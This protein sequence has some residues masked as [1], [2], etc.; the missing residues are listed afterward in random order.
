MRIITHSTV[1]ENET[2]LTSVKRLI[3]LFVLFLL[4]ATSSVT[5][6]QNRSIS[7]QTNSNIDPSTSHIFDQGCF[8]FGP[9]NLEVRTIQSYYQNKKIATPPLGSRTVTAVDLNGA[10]AGVDATI[11]SVPTPGSVGPTT[12]F[13]AFVTTTSGSMTSAVFSFTGAVDGVNELIG[14]VDSGSG[15]IAGV[16]DLGSAFQPAT[17]ITA[18]TVTLRVTNPAVGVLNV[19]RLGGGPIP[20]SDFNIF[21]SNFLYGNQLNP[22]ATEGT[23]IMNVAVT[24]PDNTVSAN[25]FINVGFAPVAVDD[26][27]SILANAVTPVTGNLL[28]NDSDPTPGDS[29]SISEVNG[30]S[31]SVG[32]P[33]A[34]TYGT[35]TV[36]AN[37]SYSYSVDVSNIAVAGLSAGESIDD[38]ISY[39]V[40]DVLGFT[41][42]GFITITING[43]DE[44]PVATDNTN[45]VTVGTSPTANG[46]VIFD[47]D[48]FGVDTADRPLAIFVWENEFSAPGGV[49]GG[50]SGPV[51]GQ[52]RTEA[53][54]GVTVSFT[55]SDPDNIGIPDQDQVVYQTFTNGGHF[56]YFGFAVDA[57]VNPSASSVLTMDFDEPVVNLSF[58]L[59]DID[60]SQGDSWQDLMTV[61]GSNGG[62]PVSFIPQVSGSVV[63]VGVD[64]FY[65][66]GSVVPE[67]AHGNVVINFPN[68]VTQVVVAYNY[69]PD[70]TAADNGGQIAAISDMIWQATGAPRVSAVDG[71]AANVGVSYATTYGFITLNS[72]GTYTYTVDAANPAVATLPVGSTLM[73]VIPYTLIDSIGPGGN[74]DT[75]NLTI[76]IN[77]SFVACAITAIA[78]VSNND[79]DPGTDTFT[80]DVTVTF[81]GAPATGTLDLTGDGTA[82]VAVGSLD[83]ATSHTFTGVTMVADGAAIDLTATFS[84]DVACTFNEPNAGTADPSCAASCGITAIAAV[85]NNDCDPGT[86]TFTA[87]VTVTFSTPPATGTL[88]LTG[89]GTASVAVGSLDTPTSHTFAGVTMAA[90]GGAIDLTAT[91][92]D[93]VACTLNEPNAGTADAS[94]APT[95]AVTAIAAVSNNDCDPGTD[96]FTADVTVN[97]IA[98]P[99]TGTLD[100]TGDGT[101]SVAVGSLDTPTSHTFAGVTMAAD[102]SAID[103]TAT[104][105]DDITCTFNEPNAGTA[106]SSCVPL[107]DGDGVPAAVEDA[108]PNG[109]DGNNDGI[110]DST[111]GNV[112]SLPD[113]SGTGT[114]VT[115]EISSS[116]CAQITNI[117]TITE[118]AVGELD[119]DFDYPV[120]LVDFTAICVNPGDSAM[121]NYWWHGIAAID[122]FRKYGSSAPGAGDAT[123]DHYLAGQYME[124][125]AGNMVPRTQYQITDDLPGDESATPTEIIDPAGPALASFPT[126]DTD[127]DTV[128]NAI[129]LDDDNDG[130]L[131]TDEMDCAPAFI[132]LGQT[133]SSTAVSGTVANTFAYGGV[134][135]TLGYELIGSN[136]GT[137]PAWVS[138]VSN[139]NNGGIAPD[140]EYANFQP[141]NTDFL[142]GDVSVYTLDFINGPVFNLEFKWGGLDNSDRLDVLASVGGTNVPVTI[143]DINLGGNLNILGPQSVFS[144][145]GGANAP[146]NSIQIRIDGPVDQVIVTTGKQ[147]G[148][149]GT[150]TTQLYEMIYCVPIDTDGDGLYDHLD[151]DADN[152][153]IYDV[154]ETGGTDVNGDGMA[155]DTDGD[156]TNNNGVPNT[157]NGGAGNPPINSD[158][159][160]IP[161]FQD[162]DSD[163]DGCSDANE[164]FNDA[165]ADGGD[166]EQ[167]GTS[168][169]L[170]IADGEVN[171]DG[172]VVA[173]DYSTGT[174]SAV[175]TP[176]VD[177]DGDGLVGACDPD[178][179]G[180][181]NP[182]TT[183]PNPLVPTA[184]DDSGTATAGVPEVIN[185]IGNDDFLENNNAGSTNPITISDTG[186]GTAGGVVTFDPDTGELTY[187]ALPGEGGTTVTVV[188]QVC[189][190]FA[191]LG[192]PSGPEDVCDTAVVT[193]T[194]AVGD[195]D[196]DGVPDDVDVCPGF[197]DNADADGDMVPDGCDED[198]DNDGILDSVECPPV[199]MLG[200]T[201]GGTGMFIDNVH[202]IEW[203]DTDWADG[204]QIG[205]QQVV[206]LANGDVVTLTVSA[207]IDNAPG[208]TD[209]W[210]PSGYGTNGNGGF[211]TAYPSPPLGRIGM[212]ANGQNGSIT[213]DIA[214][215]DAVGNTVVLD[216]VF[217]DP[218]NT[219]SV[220]EWAEANTNGSV[221]TAIESFTDPT[222]MNSGGVYSGVGTNTIRSLNNSTQGNSLFRS[223]GASQIEINMQ[224]TGGGRSA[225]LLGIFV[226]QR[227]G[228]TDTDGD[229]VIDCL[230]LDSDNDGIY[231]VVEAGGTDANNDGM[232]DGIDS[233]GNGIPDSAGTGLIPTDSGPTPGT[234]DYLDADSDEDGC[235]DAN[236]AYNDPTADGGDGGQY[237][238]DPAAVNPDG[239][240]IAAS[241]TTGAV[242]AVTTPDVDLDGDGLVGVCDPDNDG[243]GNPDTT[244]P[245][246]TTPNATD[247]A[248]A[249]DVGVPVTVS[250]LDN[251][252]YLDNNDPNNLGTTTV[253][254]TGT[255][256][257]MGTVTIDPATGEITYIPTA[258][259]AGTDVT[260]VY[261]VCNDE[262]GTPVCS[263]ATVT[264]TVS[265]LPDTDGDGIND[266]VDLDDDN[267]GILDTD[268]SPGLPPPSFDDDNDGVPNYLDPDQPG[269]VDTNGD[270][271]D[272][273]YDFDGDGIPNHFDLDADNDGIY[274]VAESGGI[275]ADNDGIADGLVD[276]NGVPSS[277]GGGNAPIE[278]TPGI[279]DHLNND[280]DGDGCTDANEAYDDPTAD[281][282]DAGQYGTDPA[283]VNPDG[284]VVA[285][286][287]GAGQSPS[288]SA[289]RTADID[290]DGDGL[291][292]AC[293]PDD[294]GDG[295]PDTTDPDPTTPNAADDADATDVGVPV[296]VSV[297]DND[298]YLD[299]NDPN[300]LGTTTVTDTGTGTAMGTVTIDPA[301]G[302]ITYIPTAAEAGTDVTIVYQV[303]NDE[304][305][306]PVC[307][308][309]TVTITVTGPDSDG[310]G[311]NDYID[312]DDDNDGILDTDESPG[313]P[314]PSFDDDNDGV[315]NYLDPDQP[316]YVDANGDGVDDR[317]DFDGDGIPN[318]LDLD[319][320]NDGIYDVAESGGTDA[321]NDGIADG[322]EDANGVPSSAGGGNTPIETTPGISDHLNNDSDGDGCTDANEAYND[323]TA[324]G[325]DAGQYGTDPAAVNP[326]GTVVAA[327]Y[328]AGQSPSPSAVTTADVDLDGDGLV[329][330]C[331]PDADGDGNPDTTD[332]DPTTPLA[333]DDSGATD[334]GVPV[335]IDI[336]GNDDYL[337]NSDPNNQGTTTITDTGTGTAGGTIVFDA[338]TGELTYTP[339][340][341]EAG[342]MVTVVY[343]VCN[344]ESG[345][346]ICV[347]ATVTIDVGDPDTDG[348]G[349]PDST[350]PDPNDPCVFTAGSTPDPSNPIWQAA[351]CDGDGTTNGDENTNGTDPNDPCEDD[352]TIGDEDT[353]NPVWQ[354]ADCDGDGVTNGQEDTD[355]TNPYDGCDYDPANQD[356]TTTSTTYQNADCDGDGVTNGDEID[357]DGNGVDDGNGTDPFDPC[358]YNPVLITLTQTAA[359]LTADCDGDGVTNGQEVIDG[360]DPLDPCDYNATSQVVANVT[361]AWNAL[362]CDGDGV[363]N[364]D[365]ITDG[366]DPQDPCDYVD[367]N[368]TVA[369]TATWNALDCD[370][371]GVTNGDEVADG[372]DPLDE[373]DLIYT[374]QTVPPS[375]A[376][377]AGD[378]DGDGVT[379][380]DEITDGTDPTD[381]CDFMLSS[382]TVPTT[383]A[384]EALDCDGDGVTNGDEIADGTDPSDPC[385]LDV[386]SQ[387][388]SPTAAW[389]A[390]DCDGDGVTNGDEVT[391]GTD[392]TD[393]C[394][395]VLASQTLPPT[396]AWND[397]DCDGDGVTNG[398]EV[399]DGTDPQDPC[400]L[401]YTSQTV[402]PTTAWN[403]TDCDGD[404]VTNGDEIT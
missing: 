4:T 51:G 3:F 318:H 96:T 125:V 20:T 404:G 185:I 330:V 95:C 184:V 231:D 309:A 283:A 279:S 335:V 19:A 88:D 158:G 247:D 311:I 50:L 257:A 187:T 36:L 26:A 92:S 241:Y 334:P 307:S 74:T 265:D 204:W 12:E 323:P 170:T 81:S 360:T 124:N 73:D 62:T 364:G 52:N 319:A 141:N 199:T 174:N 196:G 138:G 345:T 16:F 281:G 94:C 236:E 84:D 264:I 254:D 325:G 268:E 263:T 87:D 331:D 127:G 97:F 373:C 235:S 349:D 24:D 244:D 131:D 112:A 354:A 216:F 169:P 152:D 339:L 86:D 214:A 114:Y 189:N 132:A 222:T 165:N 64:T 361:A 177:L 46:D 38:I 304:S 259:E 71:S 367:G 401:D 389:D 160:G 327:A 362:D 229:G 341:S 102:G 98:P 186:L 272:D 297:L 110:L 328:G 148:N 302:E 108:G 146:N 37:G 79:C 209:G 233:D 66:T 99:A 40:Q 379:N 54:T 83:T 76:T 355:G 104:F 320:D 313:L 180:D 227:P 202:I 326:D 385:S 117:Q 15:A 113:A 150:V 246:P 57:N 363:I 207:L 115:L 80:A 6:A 316:G 1:P 305:G 39:G 167:Y 381:P 256:T 375:A 215:V 27:N 221:W 290:L 164:A 107:D 133:F 234:P 111:Q 58:T 293:D 370:G 31:A 179:D 240:V 139:Q 338:S 171:A 329:G 232:A 347:Q 288:P 147:N 195:Q 262:S 85:S 200:N 291:V 41:D 273:R 395:F 153:G 321:D 223:D 118:S 243:D 191:P 18:G 294:D 172:T 208:A 284:T 142:L 68:P 382:Q 55:S 217:T 203:T 340:P 245:D 82:S 116:T 67:D 33:F 303:C 70:A 140:G 75:A 396:T 343:E 163:D 278:T 123:Y 21:L 34:S 10:G 120:G 182:D 13:G 106:D 122:F 144:T 365:E 30:Y 130:I 126:D 14:I 93:D 193:I 357:P 220:V 230:D 403:D 17:N 212:S 267:D 78:A 155:D 253:T 374:S 105:S 225:L 238:T 100:L 59:S 388:V 42:F 312:L 332:P 218:E 63:T 181:G 219:G 211:G 276:A 308:T 159:D 391:D 157:A 134:D 45:A 28:A 285:A 213:F 77:G 23:R 269:Y 49:F 301:T 255:G 314:P 128:I 61:T 188:Y 315:P 383:P 295:N 43:V 299:N 7:S 310:D 352:G 173:A 342:M 399:A 137:T 101:A 2:L 298:D 387:T 344:D 260:I 178:D 282:G 56:G 53:T 65:G 161:D 287:Y 194:V 166:G 162:T 201:T 275:D 183:D 129:D 248:D 377:E 324:D 44:L 390:L 252:D 368:Q 371:D 103:L 190:D 121:I 119:A 198:D 266:Y 353:T 322:L 89:D 251:D 197:D 300:N 348:D 239:T 392:P 35:I 226:A 175:T 369:V 154:V 393:P 333:A 356:Y 29:I 109:G 228:N 205:D 289:V 400:S 9:E 337:D 372:T 376:W 145:A 306:T 358:D 47:D 402:P 242:A 206:N 258:A 270:G 237:G 90:D 151:L 25:S 394:D 60:W 249:T 135:I 176:D 292:G 274:D 250:V 397:A 136:P 378:C 210:T 351:D 398:D 168:D 8:R 386:A 72:D 271:V 5:L 261:Q 277:A 286:A 143:T 359:W 156:P 224:S 69:G 380:G 91:F 317:Y 384:W 149:S 192:L 22:G 350:D 366:T 32:T 280:S 346:P 336:L 11:F 296:T 48:G